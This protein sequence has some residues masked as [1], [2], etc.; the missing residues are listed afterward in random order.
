MLV[1][2]ASCWRFSRVDRFSPVIVDMETNLKPHSISP[3]CT[4]KYHYVKMY[5]FILFFCI[6]IIIFNV[7][8]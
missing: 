7:L 6:Y 1:C 8:T 4:N 3:I 5:L 2:Q